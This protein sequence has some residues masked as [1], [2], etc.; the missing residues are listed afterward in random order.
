MLFSCGFLRWMFPELSIESKLHGCSN[1][2]YISVWNVQTRDICTLPFMLPI[3]PGL[4]IYP[5]NRLQVSAESD[6]MKAL[7]AT[8]FRV[9]WRD[10]IVR[11]Q[12]KC[13]CS[14]YFQ[15]T[16]GWMTE[17]GADCRLSSINCSLR[18]RTQGR[19]SL[20]GVWICCWL[21]SIIQITPASLNPHFAFTCSSCCLGSFLSLRFLSCPLSPLF[22]ISSHGGC[23]EVAVTH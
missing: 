3:L 9:E 19:W 7:Y 8:L 17:V 18:Y 2:L 6:T 20:L 16:V 15:H 1:V 14:K 5:G 10:N 21:G 12:N 13:N 22:E 4:Y 11:D 23:L